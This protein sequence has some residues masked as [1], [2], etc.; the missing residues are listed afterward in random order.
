MLGDFTYPV[1]EVLIPYPVGVVH[2][3]APVESRIVR[4]KG[5]SGVVGAPALRCWGR[6]FVHPSPATSGGLQSTHIRNMRLETVGVMCKAQ[7]GHG[8]RCSD[9]PSPTESDVVCPV[10]FPSGGGECAGDLHLPSLPESGSARAAT[11]EDSA[12][13]GLPTVVMAHGIGAERRFGLAPFAERFVRR[14]FAVLVF[15]YRHLGESPGEPRGLVDPARQLQDYEAALAFVRSHP[16][17]DGDR[18]ALWG[19]SF[20]GGHVL[21]LAARSPAGVRA[22][23][24]LIPFVSG[25]ASTF[26]YPLRYHVPAVARGLV[27]RLRGAVGLKP[28][29]VPVVAPRGL[30]LLA[31]PD[32]FAG[33]TAMIPDD[34]RWSG[35]VPARVFLEILRYHPGKDSAR[36]S[37]PTQMTVAM[38][39][40]ICPPGASRRVAQR[41]PGVELHDFPMGHFDP[42]VDPWFSRVVAIQTEFL[43]TH[44]GCTP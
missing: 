38:E 17:L 12:A 10:L 25:W 26:A 14:G 22:V 16:E 34:A 8:R 27:D 36:I 21:S 9:L 40:T 39:D 24:S 42:Y 44:L 23:I 5:G 4:G 3:A 37:V 31:S 7:A 35:R 11:D 18:I 19:T 43:A 41:I 29:T 30:A 2:V 28:L 6:G 32:S 33:Y 20:S 15:D 13:R 1:D